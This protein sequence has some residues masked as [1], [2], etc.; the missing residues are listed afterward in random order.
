MDF[1][2]PQFDDETW[3]LLPDFFD[4]LPKPVL[5]NIWAD[6]KSTIAEAEA[7]KLANTLSQRFES[8]QCQVL[9]RRIHFDYY[10]V[11]GI[12]GLQD[13]EIVDL[14]LRIIG[15]PAGYQ[16]TSLIAAIQCVSFQG[17]TSEAMTRIQLH[18]LNTAVNLELF[19]TADDDSGP[20]VAAAIFNMAVVNE[21]VRSY[22]VMSD[23][24]PM[25]A[26]RYSVRTVPHLVINGKSHVVGVIDETAILEQIAH[27]IKNG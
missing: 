19:T 26:V 3:A 7:V 10:P 2:I 21:Q 17:M 12:M 18:R 4:H 6:E 11:I 15:L 14:G 8:I 22:L 20:L 23:E 5:L 24:F 1:Q 16:M 27:S 25:A 13:E 9:P